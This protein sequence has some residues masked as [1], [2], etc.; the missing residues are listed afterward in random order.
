VRVEDPRLLEQSGPDDRARQRKPQVVQVDDVVPGD[1][2]PDAVRPVRD[3]HLGGATT[4]QANDPQ[5]VEGLAMGKALRGPCN[6]PVERQDRNF[7]AG[8]GLG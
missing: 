1:L 3:R 7:A 2:A 5:A 8:R 4:G 6:V